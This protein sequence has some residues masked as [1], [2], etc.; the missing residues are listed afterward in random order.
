[1]WEGLSLPHGTKFG[2]CRCKIVDSRA[3]PSWSLIHGLRWSGLIKAEP[4]YCGMA[5]ADNLC[6]VCYRYPIF[7]LHIEAETKW[8]PF[9]WWHFQVHFL[10][11]KLVIMWFAVHLSLFLGVQLTVS[12]HWLGWWLGADQAASHYLSQRWPSS[13]TH[14]SVTHL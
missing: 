11:T 12:Q 2:N 10:W 1:M 9:C 6:Q 7:P 13:A 5:R 4:V 8:Q 3:F 14:I